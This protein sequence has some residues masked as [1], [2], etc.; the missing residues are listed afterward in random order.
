MVPTPRQEVQEE[1]EGRCTIG[2]GLAQ[3][4]RLRRSREVEGG[5]SVKRCTEWPASGNQV[6][7]KMG[8]RELCRALEVF[9]EMNTSDNKTG[10]G[11]G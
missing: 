1:G 6:A 5:A 7:N 11:T 10:E 8:S 9:T 2:G 4:V 3:E